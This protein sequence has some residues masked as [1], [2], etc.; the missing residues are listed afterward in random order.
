MPQQY[1]EAVTEARQL[2]KRSETDQW[3]LA[4][5]TW[6]QT[7]GSGVSIAQWA[8]DT[9]LSDTKAGRLA[10]IWQR[11]GSPA[12]DRIEFSEAYARVS[13]P[14]LADA[15]PGQV[16]ADRHVQ[17]AR[18]AVRR[19]PAEQQASVVREALTDPDVAEQVVAH[20]AT[21]ASIARAEHSA[22]AR[23]QDTARSDYELRNPKS[24]ALGAMADVEYGLTKA[25]QGVEDARHALDQLP[26]GDRERAI[27]LGQR[28]A[29]ALELFM[30]AARGD[31]LDAELQALVEGG[32]S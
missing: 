1:Q 7:K 29:A 14:E 16:Y 4:E 6:Q 25:R 27:V 32:T 9:G 2:V 3:R 12:T 18:T 23:Q 22:D 8:R 20:P 17:E 5:L 28:V 26:A 19:M 15:E 10:L 24:A 21:R 11:H 13:R 31:D 30:A